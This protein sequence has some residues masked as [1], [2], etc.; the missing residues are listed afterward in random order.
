MM[1]ARTRT[2]S[3]FMVR[4][5]S[6]GQQFG[7][8]AADFQPGDGENSGRLFFSGKEAMPEPA[9]RALFLVAPRVMAIQ[10]IEFLRNN[11]ERAKQ[12]HQRRCHELSRHLRIF[13]VRRTALWA[14]D[15]RSGNIRVAC[16]P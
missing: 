14:A 16:F 12:R 4:S 15:N 1:I 9:D 13:N 5:E 6:R 8:S 11:F 10:A 2:K 7:G 3:H